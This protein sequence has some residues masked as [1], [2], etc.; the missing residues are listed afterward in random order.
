MRIKI[1]NLEKFVKY[2][3]KNP[4]MNQIPDANKIK[5][6][7]VERYKYL[8]PDWWKLVVNRIKNIDFYFPKYI[9]H[10]LIGM[11]YDQV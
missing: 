1:T 2:H 4:Y 10:P 6:R 5:L 9:N 11:I 3:I 8:Y 7:N